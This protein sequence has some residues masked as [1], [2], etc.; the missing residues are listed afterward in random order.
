MNGANIGM[1]QGRGSLRFL[2]EP[3]SGI[4]VASEFGREKLEGNRAPELCV[5]S[6]VDNPHPAAAQLLDD[7]IL[8]GKKASLGQNN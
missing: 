2:D 8:P 4:Q 3:L 1:V 6:L 7:F 5:L